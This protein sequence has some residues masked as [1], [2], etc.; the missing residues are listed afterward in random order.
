MKKLHLLLV[1]FLLTGSTGIVEAAQPVVPVKTQGTTTKLLNPKR[2]LPKANAAG[3]PF[4]VPFVI[5]PTQD[6]FNRFTIEDVNN[7]GKTWTYMTAGYIK[8]GYDYNNPADDWAYI[9]VLVAEGETFLSLSLEMKAQYSSDK[10]CFEVGIGAEASPESMTIVMDKDDL[11][12][13]QWETYET[14]FAAPSSGLLYLGIH[15][16]SAKYQSGIWIRNIALSSLSHPIPLSPQIKSSAINGLS[17]TAVVTLPTHTLQGNPIEGN[18]GLRVD[19][20]GEQ[21]HDF[22]SCLPGEDKDISLTLPA[23]MHTITY[24]AYLTD[25]ASVLNSEPVS[26]QV[27]AISD[28]A[29]TLPLSMSLTADEYN[30]ECFTVDAN[31]DGNSW[32]YSTSEQAAQYSYGSNNADDWI[33]LPV[34]DFGSKGGA[35]DFTID[36]KCADRNSPE[37]FEI[38]AGRTASPD[39]MTA[40]M[41]FSVTN[42]IWETREGK[43]TLAE[44]GRWFVGI[45][46]TSERDQWNL[47]VRNITITAAPD[48][49]P[50]APEFKSVNF[51][52][53]QGEI[54]LKLPSL[55]VDAQPLESSVGAIVSVDGTE[56][57][58]IE[59]GTP[60]TDVPVSMELTLGRHILA[61]SAFITENEQELVSTA[62]I[63]EIIVKQPDGYVYPL[64]FFMQPTA[65]EFE[66]LPII[67]ANNDGN[68]WDYNTGA[69][70][71]VCRT[72]NDAPSDDWIFTPAF[73]IDDLS[74]IYTLSVEARAYLER[75]PETFDICIGREADPA[76]MTAVISKENMTTYLYE[77]LTASFIAPEAGNYV[78]GIHRTTGAEGHTLSI[79]NIRFEDSGLSADAP[80]ACTDITAKPDPTGALS[81][82]IGFKMPTQ[83]IRGTSLPDGTALTATVT[84]PTGDSRTVNGLPGSEQSVTLTTKDGTNQITIAVESATDG[85]GQSTTVSVRCGIDRPSSPVI[86]TTT[87]GE[88]NLSI[89]IV[90]EDNAS[91]ANGGAVLTDRLTHAVY[92]PVDESGSMWNKVAEI[93]VGTDS[94][95]LSVDPSKLQDVAFVGIS[96]INEKGESD[97]AICYGILGTPYPLPMLEDFTSGRAMY[98]PLVTPTPDNSYSTNWFFDDPGLIHPSLSGKGYKA[99]ICYEI[100]EGGASHGRLDLPKFSTQDIPAAQVTFSLF[101][102]RLA[103]RFRV[104]ANVFDQ[105]AIEVGEITPTGTEQWA[106]YTLQL[107]AEVL[108]KKWAN[109]YLEIDFDAAPQMFIMGGYEIKPIYQR[110]LAVS[111]KTN[112]E[113]V[114]GETYTITATVTNE[115]EKAVELPQT[116]CTLSDGKDYTETF[117]C[118][119]MPTETTLQPGKSGNYTYRFAPVADHLGTHTLTFELVDFNDEK[120]SDNSDYTEITISAGQHPVVTDLSGKLGS[121]GSLEL[122]WTAPEI[123]LI[124]NDDIESYTPYSYDNNIGPWLNIDGDGKD[125][126]GLGF[127]YPGMYS[128]KGFQVMNCDETGSNIEMTAY[129]G[130]QFF[131]AVT[132]DDGSAADDWLISTEVKGG[133]KVSFRFNILSSTYGA[134]SVDVL[135]STTGRETSDFTLL[136]TFSQ[137]RIGWNPLEVTLPEDARY[138]AFHYRCIDIFGIC[139]DDI[140]YSPITDA[141][142]IGYNIYRNGEKIAERL[143]TNTFNVSEAKIGDRYNVS[144][145]T[146]LLG[147]VTEHPMSNS[148]IAQLSGIDDTT[149]AGRIGIVSGQIALIGF[150]G[151]NASVYSIDGQLITQREAITSNEYIRVAPGVYLVHVNG[152]TVKVIVP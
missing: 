62:S 121:D 122:S 44:G 17:Y 76:S 53:T 145:L 12:H 116:R 101:S 111:L 61:A 18:V 126:C 36:T 11:S 41:N 129:S 95:T 142:L 59:P 119:T 50:A 34:I 84:S 92:T 47:F 29:K 15:A 80:A 1:L 141:R 2:M 94:Y 152:S 73:G 106:D 133:S 4:Q 31:N 135:Y 125:V 43:I 75:F 14:M 70:V 81:A 74:R 124:G 35:F 20:D 40:M 102:T 149:V 113:M 86:T 51:N 78:I 23:K 45:H 136:R 37:A 49:T 13:T 91:G 118:A 72:A 5:D 54:I 82:V 16:N 117:E 7:D 71:V 98:Q 39:A 96:A 150:A 108:G 88:D 22:S 60:G 120:M 87:I 112:R 109:L 99:L 58:R 26:E 79:K 127:D 146:E 46:A 21:A 85:A 147:D 6:D 144:V 115:S 10:E 89:T 134:E 30:D 143:E 32:T 114:L 28:E 19:V 97:L 56:Y 137:N 138:F 66:T 25:G 64:P 90:W 3:V 83:T 27:R 48:N 9:P 69:G 52:G 140:F 67:D 8:Y 93:P 110:Q 42:T 151:A 100:E 77:P 139:L 123:I 131:M 24:T 132:P 104:M 148:Y 63:R 57:R 33:F 38:C 107:P 55:T 128:P 130:S 103:A 105:P 68:T 65:G